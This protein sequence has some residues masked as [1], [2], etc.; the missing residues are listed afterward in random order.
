MTGGPV[1]HS[2]RAPSQFSLASFKIINYVSGLCV[3][4]APAATVPAGRLGSR[5]EAAPREEKCGL[6][7]PTHAHLRPRRSEWH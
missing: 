1:K 7:G 5:A 6:K 3:C 2:T 4:V